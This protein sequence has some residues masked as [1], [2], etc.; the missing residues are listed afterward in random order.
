MSEEMRKNFFI[1]Q[2]F[3]L[4][5]YDK[6]FYK[7]EKLNVEAIKVVGSLQSSLSV[8]YV[9][10]KKL[11]I[12]PS[13]YDICLISSP[14]HVINFDFPQVENMA[15]SFGLIAKF[16]HKLCEKHNLNLIFSGKGEKGKRSG[17][18]EINFYKHYLKNY[19]FT[20][21][22]S[23]NSK[24]EYP[25]YVNIMQS[26][27]TI[28]SISTILREA[29]SFEKKILS[30]NFTGHPD[31]AFPGLNAEFPEHSI[32]ILKKPS[33]D[34][35]EERVLKILSMTNEKYFSELGKE[36]FYMMMPV[37][38]TANIMRKKIMPY[39]GVN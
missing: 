35:F 31:V 38:K 22:Q 34:L 19:D 20:I 6:L 12:N 4:S 28:G 16:T 25:S 8:E 27:L 5:E 3:C 29:I 23:S 26:R 13:R 39:S 11:K 37:D 18:R 10:S 33:Y 14:H 17:V 7:K 15:D 32:C 36:K 1:P 21:F 2:L 24:K 30:C 9:K